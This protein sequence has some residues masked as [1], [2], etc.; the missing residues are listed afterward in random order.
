M[1]RHRWVCGHPQVGFWAPP[2][3]GRFT[4]SAPPGLTCPRGCTLNLACMLHWK[5]SA[6]TR[7]RTVEPHKPGLLW[8]SPV[9]EEHWASYTQ[10]TTAEPSRRGF[11]ALVL[12]P[13]ASAGSSRPSRVAGGISPTLSQSPTRPQSCCLRAQGWPHAHCGWAESS[14]PGHVRTFLKAGATVL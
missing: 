10:K 4:L 1:P 7:W 13:R 11:H 2:G 6:Q 14:L 9:A 5:I 3:V 8:C 12:V